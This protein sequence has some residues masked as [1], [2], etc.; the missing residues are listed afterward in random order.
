MNAIELTQP[1]EWL[2]SNFIS[3]PKRM[4]LRFRPGAKAG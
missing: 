1:P 4:P 3:G 2:A